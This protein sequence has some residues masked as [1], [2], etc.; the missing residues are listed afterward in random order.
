MSYEQDRLEEFGYVLMENPT[1]F[2]RPYVKDSI[3]RYVND[4]IMPGSFLLACLENDL[5]G[6]MSQADSYHITTIF[7]VVNYIYNHTPYECQGSK[8]KVAAWLS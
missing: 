7:A 3:D 5:K 6:A 2:L 4:H 1:K 8:E